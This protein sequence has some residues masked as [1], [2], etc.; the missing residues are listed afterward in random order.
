MSLHL[1][2]ATTPSSAAPIEQALIELDVP[3]QLT[4][5]DLS[6]K[7]HK[8][9]D[10][11]ALNPNGLV[12]TLV[13][14]EG[15]LF[16]AC[17]ILQYLGSRYGAERG[18]W[19]AAGTA[20]ELVARSWSTWAYSQLQPSIHMLIASSHPMVPDAL[21]HPPL[22]GYVR[23]QLKE[24]LT[25]LESWLEGRD[26][27]LGEQFSLVDVALSS[28]L[29]WG[30]MMGVTTEGL[31]KVEAWLARCTARPAFGKSFSAGG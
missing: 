8:T 2:A 7:E 22:E 3:H 24:R 10:Y 14:E 16:E 20:E 27:V 23:G 9:P 11:L 28:N 13:S 17:A 6:A 12:P 30:K 5:L 4:R 25:V 31:P 18:L 29:A 21:H 1:Y 26:Y 19:P 15:P